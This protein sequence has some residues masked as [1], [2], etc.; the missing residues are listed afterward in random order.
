MEELV[1]M[2]YST[3]SVH[4]YK[5]DPNINI[6]DMRDNIDVTSPALRPGY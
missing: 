4:F 3:L 1:I 2:D 6:N 5:I